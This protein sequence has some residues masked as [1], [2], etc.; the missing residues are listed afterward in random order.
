[1]AYSILDAPT[2]DEVKS[3]QGSFAPLEAEDYIVRIHKVYLKHEADYND[4]SKKILKYTLLVTPYKL[5]A[6]DFLKDTNGNV[7]P[8]LT[9]LI[10]R[11]IPS[12]SMA[13][14]KSGAPSFMRSVIAHTSGQSAD[15]MNTI[16]LP[17]ILVI[18]QKKQEVVED[19]KFVKEYI[20]EVEDLKNGKIDISD[21]EK[22][23]KGFF[24]IPDLLKVEGKYLSAKIELKQKK[25]GKMRE[26]IVSFGKVPSNF[27]PDEKIEKE[28]L[29]KL[30]ENYK[31][32]QEKNA[33]N[34]KARKTT[35]ED[36]NIEEIDY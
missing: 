23:G 3:Q 15:G 12:F 34:S 14:Q 20:K 32:Y 31:K 30:A 33:S 6:E 22:Y 2:H 35:V 4:S 27:T 36:V 21:C 7:V 8:P 18:D 13:Y 9:K 26:N 10:Y 29:D 11:T 24:H 19:E 28:A 5:K 17:G 25:D 1:M 16:A